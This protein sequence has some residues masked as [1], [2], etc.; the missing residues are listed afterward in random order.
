MTNSLT[1]IS[2]DLK[3]SVHN[4][5][6]VVT[7]HQTEKNVNSLTIP[8]IEDLKQ[9][10]QKITESG[11]YRGLV[12][13]SGQKKCFA[14][15]ADIGIFESWKSEAEATAGARS[16][17]LVFD[18][19]ANS[20]IPTVAAIHGSCLGGGLELALAC[21][22]RL[23][24]TD[25]S[26]KMGF[27]E[28]R[29]GL[30]P[31]AGGTQ[32]A[33]RL[34][35]IPSALDLILTGK[36]VDSKKA[37]KMGLIDE[38][39]PVNQLLERATALC[40]ASAKMKALEAKR[41]QQKWLT[42]NTL[43][44]AFVSYQTKKTVLK[45]TGGHYPAPFKALQAVMAAYTL[46]HEE[47]FVLESQLFG[48]CFN[49]ECSKSLIHIFRIAT[50]AKKNPATDAEIKKSDD[51]WV[52]DLARG[53]LPIGI[54]GAG[55][56]GSGIA[57]VLADKKIRTVMLDNNREGLARGS[58]RINEHF[59]SLAKKKRITMRERDLAFGRVAPTLSPASLA[60][61][62]F[63]IEAVFEDTKIK[64]DMIRQCEKE[65][66]GDFIF[67]TNTSSLPIAEIAKGAKKP[68]LVVGMHFFSPVPKMP[69]V[70][71]IKTPQT[72]PDVLAATFDIA[73]KMGK[74]VIVVNDG[75]GFYTTRVLAF[76][77]AEAVN[78][79]AEGCSVEE[80]DTAMKKFGWPVGPLTLIDEVGIDVALHVMDTMISAF[81]ERVVKVPGFWSFVGQKRLGRKSGLGFYHYENDKR[82]AVDGA[83]YSTLREGLPQRT[84]TSQE[85]VNRCNFVF[86][87]ETLRCLKDEV[88]RNTADADL[89]ALFGLGFPPHLGGPLHYAQ[90][91]G[92]K[93]FT[94]MANE[95][96]ERHGSR[97]QAADLPEL[98][99][100]W[101]N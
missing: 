18:L 77:L 87:I 14:A 85:I 26:T 41:T 88:L 24:S 42:T 80:V 37:A 94:Q 4:Q 31:G 13:T 98:L 50:A 93:A 5:V 48:Q 58:A 21:H 72:R 43:F 44:R 74:T 25:S 49:T 66:D 30:I 36:Q 55:L 52:D 34:I 86:I 73:S 96:A 40:L 35:G 1:S 68:E 57:T 29:L 75:P 27:P 53:A 2:G 81:P 23:C 69:L 6:C 10:F 99:P 3:F 62:K 54:L 46:S 59:D 16:L 8:L 79:V 92:R 33:P 76:L 61:S 32:R 38:A 17:Q 64:H 78:L 56:M 90:N 83:V 60:A 63:I 39:L 101:K 82:G 97:F 51:L 15:G 71:I 47:G 95:L 7:I 22:Y 91:M 67:A 70:E 89:G 12:V 45:T 100:T 65:I 11:E 19:L 28:V 84:S 9:A 20:K